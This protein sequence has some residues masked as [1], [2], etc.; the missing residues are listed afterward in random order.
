M[1]SSWREPSPS[2][3]KAPPK[4]ARCKACGEWVAT[5]SAGSTWVRGRCMNKRCRKYGEGQTIH[6]R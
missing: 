6:L 3:V 4:E 1:A 2:E 5:A